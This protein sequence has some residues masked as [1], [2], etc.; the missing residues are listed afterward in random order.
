MRQSKK[1]R[2]FALIFSTYVVNILNFIQCL[3]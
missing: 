1:T 2:Y 3:F